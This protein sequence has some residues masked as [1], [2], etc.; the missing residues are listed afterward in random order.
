MSAEDIQQVAAWV[1]GALCLGVA[2]FHG[3]A[4]ARAAVWRRAAFA[5]L[6][7]CALGAAWANFYMARANGVWIHRWD[8]F[9]TAIGAKYFEELGYDH[10]YDCA[11]VLGRDDPGLRFDRVRKIRDL[12]TL[13]FVRT[14]AVLKHNDCAERF[15]PARAREFVSDLRA[16]AELG[17]GS[18]WHETFKDK[19]YNG[20][21]FYTLL[22]RA[23]FSGVRLEYPVMLALALID[24]GLIAL[25]F[26][27]VWRTRGAVIALVA[28]A[29]LSVCYPARF[30]H[31]GGSFLRFDYVAALVIA[32]CAFASARPMVAGLLIGYAAFVRAFPALFAGAMLLSF[33][34]TWYERRRLPV[35]ALRF[36]QGLGLAVVLF[37][38]AT[39]VFG[40]GVSDWRAWWHEV[41]EHTRRSAA[42][43]I[44]FKHM[45]MLDGNLTSDEGF[46]SY[47]DKAAYFADRRVGYWLACAALGLPIAARVRRQDPVSFAA[48]L[49]CTLFF[50]LLVATRY[51]YAVIVVVLLVDPRTI[52]LRAYAVMAGLLMLCSAL[53]YAIAAYNSHAA[54]LNN[55]VVSSW[56]TVLTVLLAAWS[57]WCEWRERRPA[58]VACEAQP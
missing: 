2:A 22:A 46:V 23:A 55:T 33:A 3:Q 26:V 58:S 38:G 57:G 50:L 12:R 24:V 51:Y 27:V 9:H 47:A 43:R 48:L 30:V 39:F 32:L 20:T 45:F 16:F 40:D 56:L 14:K 29:L 49:G 13:E 36:C 37:G 8:L 7:V 21:P 19:G 11:Y 4:W 28:L 15:S 53:T 35:E 31:M 34:A 42:F 54:F 1:L 18:R 17:L 10:L 6:L 41:L 5:V 52:G 44:G 25:A